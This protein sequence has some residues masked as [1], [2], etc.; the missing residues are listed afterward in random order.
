MFFPGPTGSPRGFVPA[1]A[2]PARQSCPVARVKRRVEA[3]ARRHQRQPQQSRPARAQAPPAAVASVAGA[4]IGVVPL[5]VRHA[6]VQQGVR[7]PHA[8][9]A[10]DKRPH[11]VWGVLAPASPVVSAEDR[12]PAVPAA[13]ALRPVAY[14]ALVAPL[15]GGA[16]QQGR[17]ECRVLSKELAE[18]VETESDIAEKN[19][20][21]G[22]SMTREMLVR[23]N[24]LNGPD[25]E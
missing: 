18:K 10:P 23:S 22:E 13:G 11:R 15:G 2:A 7:Q 3:Q 8:A 12:L 9:G 16:R 1:P 17:G 14:P 25:F 4:G 21:L 5:G 6:V 20:S 24:N 19:K